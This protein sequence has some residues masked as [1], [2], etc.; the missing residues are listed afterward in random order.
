[1]SDH[2]K[3][4]KEIERMWAK[5]CYQKDREKRIESAK[6][7]VNNHKEQIASYQK[8]YHQ[9]RKG[10]KYNCPCGSSVAYNVK[11]RHEKSDKHQ[12]Y[13]VDSI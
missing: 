7:Y 13:L 11:S 2:S 12:Q 3:E 9:A 1:M 4:R 10:E 8:Q 6:R 5:I